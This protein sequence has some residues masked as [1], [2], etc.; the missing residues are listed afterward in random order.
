MGLRTLLELVIL[1]HIGDQGSFNKNLKAFQDAGFMTK[2]QADV[3]A[4]VIDAGSAAAH[5][6]YFPNLTDLTTC[7]DAVRYLMQGV[8]VLKPQMDAVATNTP[9]RT[10]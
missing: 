9:K 4:Y 8:Y 7:I 6:A 10:A 2:Q 1:D 5:R 3:I